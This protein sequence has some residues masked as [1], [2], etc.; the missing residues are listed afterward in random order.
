MAYACKCS[1]FR[2]HDM[3][4]YPLELDL[5]AVNLLMWMLGTKLSFY[6]RAVHAYNL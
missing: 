3:A 4:P 6:V 5:Q 1:S 2:G